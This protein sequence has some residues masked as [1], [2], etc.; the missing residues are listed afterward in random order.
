M[1]QTL[2]IIRFTDFTQSTTDTHSA[3]HIHRY[4][5][6]G[7]A[8]S[9]SGC[10]SRPFFKTG[11]PM[12]IANRTAHFRRL[13]SENLGVRGSRVSIA[14]L[15]QVRVPCILCNCHAPCEQDTASL[16]CTSKPVVAVE[17]PMHVKSLNCSLAE[18]GCLG[19]R[20]HSCLRPLG[21]ASTD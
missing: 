7:P 4:T 10:T 18:S 9:L 21:Q 11:Q 5:H 19:R 13:I 6:V 1:S 17:L 20:W 14:Y 12:T 3:H 16:A 15:S 2:L 8:I